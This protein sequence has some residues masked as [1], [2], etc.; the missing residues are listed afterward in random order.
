MRHP[1]MFALLLNLLAA[2][3]SAFRTRAELAL[4]KLALRQQLATLRRTSARPR[5]RRPGLLAR[6]LPVLAT[7]LI[8]R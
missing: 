2:L 1:T 4:E 8:R 3:R 5:L 6:A 7:K